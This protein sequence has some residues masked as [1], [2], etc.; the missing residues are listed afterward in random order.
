ML[1]PVTYSLP[2]SPLPVTAQ[3]H[4]SPAEKDLP[5]SHQGLWA[6]MGRWLALGPS[7]LSLQSSRPGS[8]A[9]QL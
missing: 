2:F 4:G 8:E 6:V 1:R 5:A 7:A 9:A 3:P